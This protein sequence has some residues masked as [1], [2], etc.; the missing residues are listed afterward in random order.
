MSDNDTHLDPNHIQDLEKK[1]MD[2]IWKIIDS[3]GFNKGLK[4]MANL[5]QKR[6][7]EI[8][9][10]YNIKN[11]YNVGF[12][13]QL[14]YYVPKVLAKLPYASPVSGD[15][16]FY[17]NDEDCII[18]IDAKVVNEN[19]KANKVDV[20]YLTL[21]P[22]QTNISHMRVDTDNNIKDSGYDYA[23]LG[24]YGDLPTSDYHFEGIKKIPIITY[25]VKCIYNCDVV[26]KEF[27][28]SR[29]DLTCAPNQIIYENLWPTEEIIAN[30]KF[31]KYIHEQKPEFD[32]LSSSEKN[33]YSR[34]SVQDF[35]KSNKIKFVKKIGN[36]SKEFYLDKNLKSLNKKL[37]NFNLAWT[38][39]A[40]GK[41]GQPKVKGYEIPISI[42]TPRL[43]IKKDRKDSN[44]ESWKGLKQK[45]LSSSS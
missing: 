44:G 21:S 1:Y 42:D 8:E 9:K 7:N 41:K 4:I 33:K 18:S 14:K 26:N 11:F 27:R 17:P 13:R 38:D 29:L 31:Y 22:H 40:R 10:L 15:L 32:R 19:V 28:L 34:V 23:G 16:A 5:I 43:L 20:D 45:L 39:V 24:F 30:A 2:E 35:N 25:A 37:K 6:F 36:A 3:E 12:E